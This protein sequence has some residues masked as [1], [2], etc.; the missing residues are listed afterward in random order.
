[1]QIIDN[2]NINSISNKFDELKR[3]KEGKV[4]IIEVTETNLGLTFATNLFY[5]N[6]FTKPYRFK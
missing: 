5:I 3:M 6:G 2:L 4:D 1:M